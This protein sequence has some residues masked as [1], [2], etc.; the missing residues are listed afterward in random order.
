MY[1]QIPMRINLW[2]LFFC[3]GIILL[4]PFTYLKDNWKAIQNN[5]EVIGYLNIVSLK[6]K[7][8]RVL[9]IMRDILYFICV[10]FWFFVILFFDI[11]LLACSYFHIFFLFNV[12][13]FFDKNCWD[14]LIMWWYVFHQCVIILTV[15][16]RY[17]NTLVDVVKT[18]IC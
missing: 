2:I 13:L 9:Y 15:F 6:V 8:A 12:K 4:L 17:F 14:V 16:W 7:R 18:L 10:D 3:F 11:P 1:F 5:R